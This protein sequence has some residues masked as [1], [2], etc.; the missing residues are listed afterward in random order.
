[1]TSLA[2]QNSHLLLLL[3]QSTVQP[4]TTSATMG[5]SN[6]IYHYHR[7][8]NPFKKY[9]ICWHQEEGSGAT[10]DATTPQ[11]LVS[12]LKQRWEKRRHPHPQHVTM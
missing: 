8:K 5:I 4:Q 1:M 6:S 7:H 12:T 10:L 9:P 2:S 11:V 3:F